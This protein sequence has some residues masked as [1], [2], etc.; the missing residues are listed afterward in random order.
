MDKKSIITI[1]IATLLALASAFLIINKKTVAI[2]ENEPIPQ[3]ETIIE[4]EP[5]V[6]EEE[7][8][9]EKSEQTQKQ[10]VTSPVK[11]PVK[12]ITIKPVE[13]AIPAKNEDVSSAS[14]DEKQIKVEEGVIVIP[15]EYRAEAPT[16][17]SFKNYGELE[18]VK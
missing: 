15:T 1:V 17:F 8:I 2:P 13:P 11:K 14:Q 4:E 12:T 16:K 18:S 3:E 7:V 5:S 10:V 9:E 6:Q